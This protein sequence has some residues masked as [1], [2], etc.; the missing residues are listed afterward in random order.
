MISNNRFIYFIYITLYLVFFILVIFS[1][2]NACFNYSLAYFAEGGRYLNDVNGLYNAW[3]DVNINENYRH[4]W[5]LFQPFT[6]RGEKPLFIFSAVLI[7]QLFSGVLFIYENPILWLNIISLFIFIILITGH[8][9]NHS[10]V[11]ILTSCFLILSTNDSWQLSIDGYHTIFSMIFLIMLIRIYKEE[12]PY[13]SSFIC[14]VVT[15]FGAFGSVHFVIPAISMFIILSIYIFVYKRDNWFYFFNYIYFFIGVSIVLIYSESIKN[16]LPDWNGRAPIEYLFHQG[17]GA[18]EWGGKPPF[19]YSFIADYFLVQLGWGTLIILC[20]GFLYSFVLKNNL[21]TIKLIPWC[22]V[23]SIFLM[24]ILKLPQIGRAYFP[25]LVLFIISSTNGLFHLF[26]KFKFNNY[27]PNYLKKLKFLFIIPL[28]SIS[29]INIGTLLYN[30][31]QSNVI[32]KE[33]ENELLKHYKLEIIDNREIIDTHY[34]LNSLNNKIV[35]ININSKVAHHSFESIDFEKYLSTISIVPIGITSF[36]YNK[37]RC[38]ENE[39][40]Y[41]GFC[42]NDWN[43]AYPNETILNYFK[44][45]HNYY[46]LGSD[47]INKSADSSSKHNA[48]K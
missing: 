37:F 34:N 7:K 39:F 17:Q 15:A 6:P 19:Y 22:C 33:F 16:Y 25:L 32:Y 23:M 18:K 40:Q 35:R 27:I 46:Y 9:Y 31:R 26:E 47:I 21:I 13:V 43:L 38:F 3:N 12:K 11:S 30:D 29:Y 44:P 10:K 28:F 14:G 24:Y 42:R 36:R 41:S 20:I 1:K 2:C 45:N 8:Y 4:P 5:S 48:V